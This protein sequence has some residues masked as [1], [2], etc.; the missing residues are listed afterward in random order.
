MNATHTKLVG[1][2]VFQG[3]L[4][5]YTWSGVGGGGAPADAK[6]LVDADLAAVTG[7]EIEAKPFGKDKPAKPLKL[8]KKDGKWLVASAGD[9]EAKTDKVEEVLKKVLDLKVRD[10]IASDK[11]NH[12]SLRVG[13]R[14]YDKKV[15]VTV[16]GTTHKVVLGSAKGS[17][18]HVRR[19]DADEVYYARGLSS[20]AL[21]DQVSGYIDTEYFKAKNP[22]DVKIT[23]EHGT[24]TL[25]KDK[26][27]D[28]RLKELAPGQEAKAGE[29]TTLAEKAG[30]LRMA[31]PVGKEIKDEYG[32]GAVEVVVTSEEKVEGEEK[33]K[34]ETLS[35]ALG[36]E[37]DGKIYAKLQ[38]SPYV[39]LVSKWSVEKLVGAKLADL[40]K[41]KE[42]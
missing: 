26:D 41:A 25:S 24:L 8:V 42:G 40:I 33:P 20:W 16:G 10:P 17:A 31:E 3:L 28:W 32:L 19:G 4:G 2:L 23:N 34:S 1:L 36:K 18:V 22:V 11:A 35:F 14:E 12:N 29:L 37:V 13:D 7:L 9:Y 6:A 15:A 5:A 39:V 21:S 27:G 30:S 38:D